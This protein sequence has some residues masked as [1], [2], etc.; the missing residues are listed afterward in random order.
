MSQDW[1]VCDARTIPCALEK[2]CTKWPDKIF[3]DFSGETYTYADVERESAR[4]AHGLSSIGVAPGDRVCAMLDNNV[5][6]ILAWFGANRIGAV[7]VPINTDLK[8]DFLRHQLIDAD[9]GVMIAE[10]AYA[11]RILQIERSIP[12]M[13]TLVCRGAAPRGPSRLTVR[14]IEA[15]RSSSTVRI[16][17]TRRPDNLALLIYTSGT[18]GV[19]KGCMVSH[20]Y[21]CHFGLLC[22]RAVGLAAED[23]LWTPC[24]LFHMAAASA[25]V[26]GALLNGATAA[27]HTR[28]S[29][30]DFWPEIERSKATMAM[31]LSVMLSIVPNALDT[32][33]SKRCHGQLRVV[34]GAPLNTELIAAWTERFGVRYVASP[35]YALTEAGPIVVT[36]VDTPN[37]PSGSSG[38]RIPEFDVRIVDENGRECPAGVAGEVIV[39]PCM[40]DI[41]FQGYWRRPDAMAEA[42]HGPWFHTGDLGRFD[43]AGFFFF[44]DRKKDC[45]RRGGE[46]IASLEVEAIISCH[47]GVAE[48]AVHSVRSL[49]AEDEVKATIVI[50]P[51][52]VLTEEALCRWSQ[53]RLPR[54][55]VPRYIEFRTILPRS[56]TGRV[57]KFMLRDEGVTERTWDRQRSGMVMSRR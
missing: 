19:S 15:I 2:A 50:K 45:I 43:K 1:S 51:G 31:L 34:F 53:D 21:A 56:A 9:P 40:P 41:M 12:R 22:A 36:P 35:C 37:V 27:I 18:A 11:E 47:P 26:I 8:G 10:A 4:I 3:L 14:G 7:F 16:E 5:D 24:P 17:D 55:A 44:V 57:Q 6:F 54:F 49:V 48:V 32:D 42:F 13:H 30:S 29:A 33:T 28:F 20:N 38:H 25:V 46:N 23:V 52:V 39:R